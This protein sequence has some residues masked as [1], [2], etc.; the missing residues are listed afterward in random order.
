[1]SSHLFFIFTYSPFPQTIKHKLS[2][3]TFNR[4]A[5]LFAILIAP[6]TASQFYLAKPINTDGSTVGGQLTDEAPRNVHGQGLELCSLE[7]LTGYFRNGYCETIS[8]DVGTHTVCAK[9][10]QQFLEYTRRHGND[11]STPRGAFPG[12]K[13]GDYWCLCASRWQ[14]AMEN[15]VAPPVKLNATHLKTLQVVTMTDLQAHASI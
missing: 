7:P 1:M 10:T 6:I 8:S 3:I 11:L 9:V 2:S 5:W 15:Q 14:Q 4:T 13:S 12:L